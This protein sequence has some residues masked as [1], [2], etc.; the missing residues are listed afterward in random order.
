[1]VKNKIVTAFC[2]YAKQ[3]G[4]GYKNWYCGI[5]SIPKKRLFEEHNVPESESWWI[6]ANAGNQEDARDTELYLLQLGFDG[7]TGGG[8]F[9]TTHVY[10]YRKLRTTIE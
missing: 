6:V 3:E 5:A 1:M 8:H 7:G 10:A 4:S 2:N 9:P